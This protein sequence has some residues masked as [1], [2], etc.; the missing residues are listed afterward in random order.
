V[1]EVIMLFDEFLAGHHD[2]EVDE[3]PDVTI[4]ALKKVMHI[5]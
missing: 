5:N 3:T 4:M 1:G 2:L